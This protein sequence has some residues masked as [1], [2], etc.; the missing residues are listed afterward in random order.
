MDKDG[1]VETLQHALEALAW[2][3]ALDFEQDDYK[4]GKRIEATLANLGHPVRR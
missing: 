1:I 2:H 4:I 3:D